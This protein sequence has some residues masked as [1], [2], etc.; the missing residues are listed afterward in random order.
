MR[1]QVSKRVTCASLIVGLLG[2]APGP[3][4]ASEDLET[5]ITVFGEYDH[6][7]MGGDASTVLPSDA[8]IT[9]TGTPEELT[10]GAW[11]ENDSWDLSFAAPR[12]ERLTEK[13][14]EH[15]APVDGRTE[16]RAGISVAGNGW[17]CPQD[18]SGRFTVKRLTVAPD[19]TIESLWIL[20]E[21]HCLGWPPKAYGEVRYRVPGEGGVAVV[22]PRAIDWGGVDFKQWNLLVP[23]RV[24]NPS[25]EPLSLGA[26]TVG[27]PDAQSFKVNA[28]DCAGRT[29]PPGERCAIWVRFLA[30]ARG[31]NDATLRIAEGSGPTHETA[32]NGVVH[33]GATRLVMSSDPEDWTGD[34]RFYDFRPS[35]TRFRPEGNARRIDF[36]VRGYTQGI[37]ESYGMGESYWDVTAMAPPGET[38][39]VGRTYRNTPE[40]PH[41]VEQDGW[42]FEVSG[43]HRGCFE[44]KDEFTIS[45][46]EINRFGEI[47]ELGM[48]FV[49]SCG[50]GRLRGFLDYRAEQKHEPPPPPP[51]FHERL[52]EV[53]NNNGFVK[54]WKF[55]YDDAP[56]VCWDRVPVLLYDTTTWPYSLMARLRTN[57]RGGFRYPD[58]GFDVQ[59]ILPVKYLKS[60]WVCAK[61]FG[62]A[63]R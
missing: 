59:V 40:P 27:G 30:S 47:E 8:N 50:P 36:H 26:V 14:Y 37:G 32:L 46:L 53:Y 61:V 56:A 38:L 41:P 28:S 49:Q 7:G 15:A 11:G 18:S 13:T 52:L 24:I 25:T 43:D 48:S 54:G 3:S 10:V 62:W 21:H 9:V 35:S 12:G 5:V 22:S 45:E 57:H 60:G 29:L 42:G 6:F 1:F 17:G 33:G 55:E 23:V 39:Q 31:V 58:P 4:G 51:P 63:H 34:G 2:I 19:D 16:E 44:T 20:F